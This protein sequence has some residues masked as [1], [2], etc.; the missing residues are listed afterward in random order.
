VTRDGSESQTIY[1][2]GHTKCKVSALSPQLSPDNTQ[3]LFGL[4]DPVGKYFQL[5][6]M[7]LVNQQVKQLTDN[8]N[9][10]GSAEWSPDGT[11]IAFNAIQ[12]N[13]RE[14][15]VMDADGNNLRRVTH[16][17]G[18]DYAPHW[19]ADSKS[20]IF[21][22]DQKGYNIFNL[23]VATG[24]IRNLT[25]L[26]DSG[27]WNPVVSPDGTQIAYPTGVDPVSGA[28]H[29]DVLTLATGEVDELT[30]VGATA[31]ALAWRPLPK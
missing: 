15:F 20:L 29:I 30:G 2:Q 10:N 25:N 14:I 16:R 31:Y 11:Q 28:D 5:Y 1:R 17:P 13:Q 12:D 27:A 21:S 26:T 3:I 6:S 22:S 24:V 8:R 18:N 7:S 19:L 23:D 4:D 9:N